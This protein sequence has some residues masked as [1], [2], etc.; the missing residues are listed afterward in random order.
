MC[1]SY[2]FYVSGKCHIFFNF[3]NWYL[4][5][6]AIAPGGIS[7]FYDF[8]RFLLVHSLSLALSIESIQSCRFSKKEQIVRSFKTF[9]LWA[10][11]TALLFFLIFIFC[12]ELK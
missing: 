9:L 3:S 2:L 5:L 6:K 12:E 11:C 10:C 1:F 8:I 4:L 7:Y